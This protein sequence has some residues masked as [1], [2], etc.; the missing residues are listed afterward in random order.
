MA[1]SC[2][3]H[4]HTPLLSCCFVFLLRSRLRLALHTNRT[5]ARTHATNVKHH[6]EEE[7]LLAVSVL[8]WWRETGCSRSLL[9]SRLPKCE[10]K[11]A[12]SAWR[13]FTSRRVPGKAVRRL[14]PKYRAQNPALP[15]STPKLSN[16][17][18]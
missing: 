4:T 14:I 6:R 18:T 11:R 2:V 12:K 15:R 8:G 5:S 1:L 9:V 3:R 13:V 17:Y 7:C 10:Q 16:F